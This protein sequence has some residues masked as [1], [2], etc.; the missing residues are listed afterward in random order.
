MIN[1]VEG[2]PSD[3]PA[4]KKP[5]KVTRPKSPGLIVMAFVSQNRGGPLTPAQRRRVRKVLNRAARE[6]R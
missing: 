5:G 4:T 1:E 6:S 3:A 2:Q